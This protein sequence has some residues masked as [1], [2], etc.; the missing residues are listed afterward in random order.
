MNKTKAFYQGEDVMYTLI[1]PL[2]H[3]KHE[4]HQHFTYIGN[5]I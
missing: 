2:R 4:S 1:I 5:K 3:K